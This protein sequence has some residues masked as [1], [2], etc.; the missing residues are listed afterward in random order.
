MN[1][2][3]TN[4]ITPLTTPTPAPTPRPSENAPAVQR[5]Q[6]DSSNQQRPI[7]KGADKPRENSRPSV[8]DKDRSRSDAPVKARRENSDANQKAPVKKGAKDDKIDSKTV[9]VEAGMVAADANIKTD[10][11]TA[12]S[13]SMAVF[14]TILQAAQQSGKKAVV[15]A[16]KPKAADAV[17][18]NPVPVVAETKGKAVI[19]GFVSEQPAAKNANPEKPAVTV[20]EAPTS[21]TVLPKT[22][23]PVVPA[24]APQVKT[25]TAEIP[26]DQ[27]AGINIKGMDAIKPVAAAAVQAS[28]TSEQSAKPAQPAAAQNGGVLKEGSLAAMQAAVAAVNKPGRSTVPTRG[29]AHNK[30]TLQTKSGQQVTANASAT[31]GVTQ[32][33]VETL[34]QG[35]G[36]QGRFSVKESA[37]AG[38]QNIAVASQTAPAETSG[39]QAVR[40]VEALQPGSPVRQIADAFRSSS[41]RNGQEIVL[42]L[43]P[44]HLGTVRVTLR[45]EGGEVHGSLDV[46]NPRTL[47]QLQREAPGLMARL[48]EAGVE[49][50][51][52]DLSLNQDGSRGDSMRD[53]AWF[54]QQHGENGSGYG[55]FGG[56]NQG[57]LD[58]EALS[59]EL[60]GEGELIPA[61]ATVGDDSINVWM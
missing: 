52:M 6:D 54:A 8:S 15:T 47:S 11:K 56:T 44:P 26:V 50:K 55:A 21:Q 7:D 24:Q 37:D 12:Q 49:M 17:V 10:A 1:A 58:D 33:Q 28:E 46:D 20:A 32:K 16:V 60:D 22:L 27:F 13:G 14:S 45:V 51:R 4:L 18:D 59:G 23:S 61:L 48:A 29:A 35:Q 40:G 3:L 30:V 9:P 39:Y 34:L 19:K 38:Q 5:V 31:Q 25:E 43:D 2:S 41:A 53:S 42:R 36:A 57:R